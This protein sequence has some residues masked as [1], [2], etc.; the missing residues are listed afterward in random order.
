MAAVGSD[1]ATQPECV[2]GAPPSLQQ[3]DQLLRDLSRCLDAPGRLLIAMMGGDSL[4][5][6]VAMARGFDVSL[7]ESEHGAQSG[8]QAPT[9]LSAFKSATAGGDRA[10][11]AARVWNAIERTRTP[12]AF[13]GRI[14]GYLRPGARIGV[15]TPLGRRGPSDGGVSHLFST[16]SLRLALLRCGF[17]LIEPRRSGRSEAVATRILGRSGELAVWARK[18]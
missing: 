7:V 11:D 18:R 8:T 12:I 4:L 1:L 10:F 14:G 2:H 15:S 6:F 9:D 5:G 13:L 3:C 17:E 16:H